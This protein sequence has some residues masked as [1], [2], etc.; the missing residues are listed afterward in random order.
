MPSKLS[1]VEVVNMYNEQFFY[2]PCC[3]QRKA[4]EYPSQT[5]RIL[6]RHPIRRTVSKQKQETQK[7]MVHTSRGRARA[8][9]QQEKKNT[10]RNAMP[11]ISKLNVTVYMFVSWQVVVALLL[12]VFFE[13]GGL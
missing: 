9:Q 10:M 11:E 4:I 6:F 13:L 1:N 3:S 5:A 8:M 2:R 12:V 7:P